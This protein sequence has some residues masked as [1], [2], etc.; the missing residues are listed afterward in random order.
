MGIKVAGWY[1]SRRTGLL[2]FLELEVFAYDGFDLLG[3]FLSG[4][5]Q[6]IG[7]RFGVVGVGGNLLADFLAGGN[8]TDGVLHQ[9]EV[10]GGHLFPA[11][12]RVR[13]YLAF[14]HGFLQEVLNG[15][16]LGVG[17]FL[18]ID[19]QPGGYA[20]EV[21][22]EIADGGVLTRDDG[23]GIAQCFVRLGQPGFH[24]GQLRDAGEHVLDLVL[25]LHAERGDH[26][27]V[28]RG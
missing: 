4:T 13:L 12:H 15:A 27:A 14:V 23:L 5:L 20:V 3:D 28:F 2:Q 24:T 6:G 25:L 17:L 10:R 9:L 16:C 19:L 1:V 26:C 18:L 21:F 7:C 11:G 22:L 8:R